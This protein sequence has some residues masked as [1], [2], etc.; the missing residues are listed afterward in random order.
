MRTIDAS[1]FNAKC[2]ALIDEVAETGERIMILKEG[3]AVAELVPQASQEDGS[4]LGSLKGEAEAVGDIVSPAV[5]VEAW[6]VLRDDDEP[7]E[8]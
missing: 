3:R 6:D 2:L 4:L 8:G 5:P 1:E 7:N